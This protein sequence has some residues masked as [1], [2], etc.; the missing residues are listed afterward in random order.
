M[1]EFSE[2]ENQR[3]TW[4]G[5]GVVYECQRCHAMVR[6]EEIELRG[7]EV[8]CIICGFKVLKKTKPPVVKRIKAT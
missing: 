7:G 4:N 6:G 1:S 5:N 2:L 8:K 3:S